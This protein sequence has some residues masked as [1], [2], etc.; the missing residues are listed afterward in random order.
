M[1]AKFTRTITTTT[2]I[3]K[4]IDKEKL[5]VGEKKIVLPVYYSDCDIALKACQ[6]IQYAEN[7]DIVIL[8]VVGLQQDEAKYEM[9]LDTFLKYA[10]KIVE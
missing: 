10:T 5:E 1:A 3:V 7:P 2:A 9:T 8:N 4:Y 6:K